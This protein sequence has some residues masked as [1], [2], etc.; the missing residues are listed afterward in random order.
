MNGF[1]PTFSETNKIVELIDQAT[2]VNNQEPRH[3]LGASEIGGHC[4]RAVW[5][6]FRG[7]A[8]QTH[9]GRMLRLFNRGHEEEDRLIR[10]LRMAGAEVRDRAQQLYERTDGKGYELGEWDEPLAGPLYI[11]VSTSVAHREYA[12][13]EFKTEA[14]QWGFKDGHFQGSADG[15]ICWPGVLPDG[16]GLAEFK[17]H[18]T[19]SFD[20]LLKKG[21]AQSKPTHYYQ[22]QIYM[23]KLDLKWGLYLAVCKNDD[24]L[25]AEIVR[26]DAAN[27]E[28]LADAAHAIIAQHYAPPRF[29]GA[30]PSNFLCR[31][32]TFTEVCHYGAAPAKNC[33]SCVCA[34]AR[35]EGSWFC[36]R[37]RSGIPTSF[38]AKGCELW[39]PVE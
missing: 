37:H 20:E 33:K 17:T 27:A 5:Y 1:A 38:L 35:P 19:K 23:Y 39:N 14:K 2:A 30:D 11:D 13:E 16:W 31:F 25:Y 22:M 24:R 15:K 10:W 32:C 28:R 21:M 29:K 4:M 34:T 26:Y 7:V 3:H 9:E 36:E 12:A 6:S 8:S 18:N